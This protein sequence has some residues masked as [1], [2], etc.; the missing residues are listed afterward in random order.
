MRHSTV[1]IKPIPVTIL[2]ILLLALFWWMLSPL[3][4]N[5]GNNN[6]E[7]FELKGEVKT[8]LTREYN[9]EN[10][11]GE[12]VATS[13][14]YDDYWKIYYF[15]KHGYLQQDELHKKEEF[16]S[17][18]VYKYANDRV[19]EM[20]TYDPPSTLY[21][22]HKFEYFS[23]DHYERVVYDAD[24]K[25]VWKMVM[26][27]EENDDLLVRSTL[28]YT[29]I[30]RGFS[31]H[32]VN[33]FTHDDQNRILTRKTVTSRSNEEGQQT[34]FLE[35]RY[36]SD[37]ITLTFKQKNGGDLELDTRTECIERDAKGN[38][39]KNL[40]YDALLSEKEPSKMVVCE[41]EYH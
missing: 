3:F 28:D 16:L 36:E 37:D 32:E 6:W 13:P 9:V 29:N 31:T 15:D 34:E 10:K 22:V 25:S 11:F 23:D 7:A 30:V 19:I 35:Y 33:E 39:L 1:R 38:C 40:V 8:Y 27:M 26:K 41:I 18:D 21:E 5:E 12:W 17:K 2:A 4:S 14:Y 20:M 24:G